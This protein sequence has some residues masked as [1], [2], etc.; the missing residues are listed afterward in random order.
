MAARDDVIL[1]VSVGGQP[2]NNGLYAR[3]SGTVQYVL[4]SGCVINKTVPAG[5]SDR[6]P[7][8]SVTATT[9][10]LGLL[11]PA[12]RRVTEF[13]RTHNSEIV[14]MTREHWASMAGDYIVR[15]EA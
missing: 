4:A 3:T 2:G 8:A 14:T 6:R 10:S 13:A 1:P 5:W 12:T 11:V 9:A 15:V 7:V